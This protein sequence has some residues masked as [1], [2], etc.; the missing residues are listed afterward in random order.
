MCVV[1]RAEHA[2]PIN[3]CGYVVP[4]AH[5]SLS[6][7][8]GFKSLTRLKTSSKILPPRLGLSVTL[9]QNCTAN[10]NKTQS[11]SNIPTRRS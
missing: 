2:R 9:T 3:I 1:S 7:R 5:S 11:I 6:D 10:A 4:T 8:G